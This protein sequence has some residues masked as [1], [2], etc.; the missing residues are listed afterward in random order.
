MLLVSTSYFS[1]CLLSFV[2]WLSSCYLCLRVFDALDSPWQKC[3]SNA[4]SLKPVK[5]TVWV[6][7]CLLVLPLRTQDGFTETSS[8]LQYKVIEEG[9]GPIPTSGQ[10]IKADY[11]GSHFLA[12]RGRVVGVGCAFVCAVWSRECLQCRLAGWLWVWAKIWLL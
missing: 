10:R 9:T 12:H 5:S 3:V 1:P 4:E 2:F 8:G 6:G 7:W 11:T